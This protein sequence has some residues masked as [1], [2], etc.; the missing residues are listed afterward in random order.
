[1]QP[2]RGLHDVPAPAVVGGDGQG[3][4]RVARGPRFAGA[5]QLADAR[6]ERRGVADH[7]QAD[8]VL[9]ELGDFL[10]EARA[11]KAASASRPRRRGRRQFSLEGEQRQ[12][13][14]AAGDAGATVERT[15]STPRRWPATRGRR[16]CLAQRPLPSMMIATCRGAGRGAG[17]SRV[18]LSN[19]GSGL[20]CLVKCAPKAW[21]MGRETIRRHAHPG[22]L[23]GHQV[24]FL[25]LQDL[26]D[27]A[28]RS[29]R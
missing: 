12:E 24:R 29:D 15:A 26:V 9:V 1:M 10:L 25:G 17:I 2:L 8:A 27:I 13:L 16:R 3:Q 14:D 28:R 19:T 4:A 7:A 21:A 11:R 23:H 6:L 5:D 18:E 22:G 20:G